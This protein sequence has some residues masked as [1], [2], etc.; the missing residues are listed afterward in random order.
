MLSIL[1]I[2]Y[3]LIKC[4]ICYGHF[5]GSNKFLQFVRFGKI[6]YFVYCVNSAFI[7]CQRKVESINPP[8]PL[9]DGYVFLPEITMLIHLF[10]GIDNKE[11]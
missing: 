11:L 6:E 2:F 1:E 4:Y 10:L 7:I 9:K 8:Q 5:G 3:F